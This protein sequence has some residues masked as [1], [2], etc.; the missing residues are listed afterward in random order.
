MIVVTLGLYYVPIHFNSTPSIQVGDYVDIQN[1]AG[2][3][4]CGTSPQGNVN[5][6]ARARVNAQVILYSQCCW[7]L[8]IRHLATG[9]PSRFH[10]VYSQRL[11]QLKYNGN[12]ET[13]TFLG[14]ITSVTAGV[15][16]SASGFSDNP[17]PD[18]YVT[19]NYA[20][21]IWTVGTMDRTC[22]SDSF[23]VREV[24]FAFDIDGYLYNHETG[25][26]ADGGDMYSYVESSPRKLLKMVSVYTW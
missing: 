4:W 3:F 5:T 13:A 1:S 22:W 8:Q 2:L 21:N 17:E 23:G 14:S 26:S 16:G 10:L 19:F 12:T 6:F 18:S 11:R 7:K 20:H 15:N 25:N 9:L 24:P